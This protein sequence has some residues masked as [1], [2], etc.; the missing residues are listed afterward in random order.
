MDFFHPADILIPKDHL[1]QWATVACDQHTSNPSYWKEVERFVG[2]FPSSLH[3]ILP[4]V[5][6]SSDNSTKIASINRTMQSYLKNNIF[7]EYKN[8]LVYLERTLPSGR[9]RR[10]IVGA[11]DLDAYDFKKGSRSPIRA[12]EETVT[13][14][15]PPRVAVR[16]NALFELSHVMLLINDSNKTVIEPLAKAKQSFSSLYDFNLML[17][18][19]HVKGS[20]VSQDCTDEIMQALDTL[21]RSS[22]FLFAVGDG[23]HSLATA[24]TCYE[25]NPS[26]L[27]RSTLVEVVN[28]HDEALEFEPIYRVLFGVNPIELLKE[29]RNYFKIITTKSTQEITVLFGKTEETIRIPATTSHPLSTLQNFLDD[30][31]KKHPS[32]TL[33]Y[34]HGIEETRSLARKKNTVGFLF[35]GMKKEELFPAVEK[36]GSLVRKSFSMGNAADKRYYIEARKIQ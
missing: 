6:L 12:T 22:P 15:I 20:L 14:R 1:S 26:R 34:I 23:N 8:A 16:Q 17:G 28:I 7:S 25:K 24:K 31:L 11:V 36:D 19:G 33:D 21:Y 9:I 3:V 5:Y 32:V 29:L 2:D 13:K 30:Y 27:S 18:G 35:D 4:E 10:G